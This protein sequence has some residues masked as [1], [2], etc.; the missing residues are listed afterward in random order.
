VFSD[1]HRERAA[2]RGIDLDDS[3]Q[4]LQQEIACGG[5]VYQRLCE[6]LGGF[7]RMNPGTRSKVS[8]SFPR[9]GQHHSPQH[10]P[11]LSP[12]ERQVLEMSASG[13]PKKVVGAML[14]ITFETVKSHHR[15]ILSKLGAR[16]ITHAVAIAFRQ[17]Q[18]TAE[19]A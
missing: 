14:G 15:N 18:I 6:S 16:N 4:R 7:S 5:P 8:K 10:V 1:V 11:M 13:K 3:Y 2:E 17:G 9:Q 12:R 19:E